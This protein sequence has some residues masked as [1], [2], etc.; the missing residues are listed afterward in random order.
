[1]IRSFNA[2]K[3]YD[4]FLLEQ[5]AG[6]ELEDYERAPDVTE[7]MMENLIATG[8]LRMGP[9]STLDPDANYVDER[10]DVVSDAMDVL[11]SGV[12]GL[13]GGGLADNG[14]VFSRCES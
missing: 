3:P 14:V 5:I 7:Q 12:T 9:D 4:R 11:G 6:D 10:M 2:D 13:S 1:V 8:F